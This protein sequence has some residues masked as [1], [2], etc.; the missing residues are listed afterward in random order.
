ME[1]ELNIIQMKIFYMMD[2]LLMVNLKEKENI[3]MRM[4]DI[5]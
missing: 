2:I 3:F 1:K 5:I 4:V